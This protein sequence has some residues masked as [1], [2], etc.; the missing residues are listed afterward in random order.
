VAVHEKGEGLS[1]FVYFELEYIGLLM[2]RFNLRLK[3]NLSL[4]KGI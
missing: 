2:G 1:L 4:Q 3:Y